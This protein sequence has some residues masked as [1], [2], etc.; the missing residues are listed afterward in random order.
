MWG[1]APH[2]CVI[3]FSTNTQDNIIVIK[4]NILSDLRVTKDK[5]NHLLMFLNNKIKKYITIESTFNFAFSKHQKMLAKKKPL[6][7]HK[8]KKID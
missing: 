2:L 3:F 4:K 6:M 8:K 5:A 1:K 7:S